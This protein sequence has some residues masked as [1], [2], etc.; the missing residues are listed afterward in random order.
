ME[1]FGT[2]L[3]SAAPFQL[4]W[5]YGFHFS[6]FFGAPMLPWVTFDSLGYA[7]ASQPLSPSFPH[8]IPKGRKASPL[9]TVFWLHA[10]L[11]NETD[12]HGLCSAE[13]KS[14]SSSE[15]RKGACLVLLDLLGQFFGDFRGHGLIEHCFVGDAHKCPCPQRIQPSYDTSKAVGGIH[16]NTRWDK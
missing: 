6:I 1:Y 3:P 12:S 5:L 16:E 11:W 13:I 8:T 2:C 4:I 14:S 10:I 7:P 15:I 9:Q